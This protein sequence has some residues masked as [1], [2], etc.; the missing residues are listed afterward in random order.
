MLNIVQ[1]QARGNNYGLEIEFLG[2]KRLGLPENVTASVFERMQSERKVLAERSQSEGEKESQIIRSEADR[3][4]AEVLAS[5]GAQ[6]TEIRGQ[7]EAEAAKSLTVFQKDPD[8]AN[9]IFRLTALEGSLKDRS[10]LILDQHIPPFDLFGGA[11]TN[12]LKPQ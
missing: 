1:A 4:A 6:A 11:S 8:L 5:A 3:K 7:G 12:L 9:F 2:I 10:T